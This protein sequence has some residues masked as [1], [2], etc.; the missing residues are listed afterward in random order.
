MA[1]RADWNA[2]A[3][4]QRRLAVAADA[5]LRRRHPDQRFPALRSAEPEP[6]PEP[7]TGT[8]C[9]ELT[10]TAWQPGRWANHLTALN[11]VSSAPFRLLPHPPHAAG[12]IIRHTGVSDTSRRPP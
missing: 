6:E 12:S 8:Q 5:G 1:D 3:R 10:L 11:P 2:A 7:A 9:D 4:A